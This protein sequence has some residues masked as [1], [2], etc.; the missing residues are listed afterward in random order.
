[1]NSKIANYSKGKI[2]LAVMWD[3]HRKLLPAFDYGRVDEI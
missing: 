1:M 3:Q 2:D